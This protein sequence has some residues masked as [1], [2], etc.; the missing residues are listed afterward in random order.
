MFYIEN[1]LLWFYA[2]SQKNNTGVPDITKR[3][4]SS[5][6]VRQIFFFPSDILSPNRQKLKSFGEE[7]VK[8]IANP[9]AS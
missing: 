1:S 6:V 8:I 7:G 5:K 3:M 9:L 2:P 4:C